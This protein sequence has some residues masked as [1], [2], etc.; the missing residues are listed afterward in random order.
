MEKEKTFLGRFLETVDGSREDV[1]NHMGTRTLTETREER[2]QDRALLSSL[3]TRTAT[4]EQPESLDDPSR[5]DGSC[6]RDADRP[7]E[8][9]T[10]RRVWTAP[11]S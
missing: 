1:I 3:K 5:Q 10:S 9:W 6:P 7:R 8:S 4:R 2:D 11:S